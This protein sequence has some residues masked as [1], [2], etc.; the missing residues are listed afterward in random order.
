MNRYVT[1]QMVKSGY[2]RLRR[3]SLLVLCSKP[4]A[5]FILLTTPFSVLSLW[6]VGVLSLQAQFDMMIFEKRPPQARSREELNAVLDIVQATDQKKIVPL[7][8]DF[9]RQ[10]PSS[11]FACQVYRMEM[12]AHKGLGDYQK[13]IEAGEKALELCSHDV[14][15]LLS[16]A[17][18]L[19]NGVGDVA[20]GPVSV[21]DK[22]ERYARQ[23]LEEI[24]RLKATRGVPLEKWRKLTGW[25]RSSAHEALGFVAFKRGH[26]AES[27]AE[28][29]KSIGFNPE[30]GG[31]VFFRLGVAYL[32]DGRTLEAQVALERSSQLG[33][34]F[35]R[36]KA[37]E[38]LAKFGNR[39]K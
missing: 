35:I 21:L 10:F 27:V 28:L 36:V 20:N 8:A 29:E 23:A 38:Q 39:L 7:C 9:R 17:N 31:A 34:E 18:A 37:A 24:D 26:Y 25:M 11:E 3:E 14:D 6:I 1:G 32:Y 12:H 30:A 16:L 2:Q 13:M 19:P 5:R 22:A 4:P 33:P 15:A